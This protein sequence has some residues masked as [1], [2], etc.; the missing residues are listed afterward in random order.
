MF[1]R[2]GGTLCESSV[3]KGVGDGKGKARGEMYGE[4]RI[5]L[6]WSWASGDDEGRGKLEK[7]TLQSLYFPNF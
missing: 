6:G 2:N 3:R 4:I 7:K 5:L 1:H